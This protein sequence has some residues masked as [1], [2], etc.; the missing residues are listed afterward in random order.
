M[1]GGYLAVAT[2]EGKKAGQNVIDYARNKES[3]KKA[4]GGVPK[5]ASM[6]KVHVIMI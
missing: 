1:I 2:K 3:P 4:V 6:Y 5:K